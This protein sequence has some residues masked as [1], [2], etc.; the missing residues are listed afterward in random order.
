M[1]LVRRVPAIESWPAFSILDDLN[2][3]AWDSFHAFLGAMEKVLLR[4]DELEQIKWQTPQDPPGEEQKPR[5]WVVVL[6][7]NEIGIG[8]SFVC[9]VPLFEQFPTERGRFQKC[10]GLVAEKA[11]RL[12]MMH[13]IKGHITSSQSANEAKGEYGGSLWLP[14]RSRGFLGA[15]QLAIS[16][17][18]GGLIDEAAGLGCL[19]FAKTLNREQAGLIAGSTDNVSSW[20]M[21]SNIVGTLFPA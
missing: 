12:G 7:A 10:S 17:L 1:N 11:T 13:A 4:F 2:G 8:R 14:E 19:E 3:V 16:G 5:T 18:P 6:P 9:G 21:M 15:K 20:I